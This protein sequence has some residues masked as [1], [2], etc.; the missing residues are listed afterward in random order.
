MAKKKERKAS[1]EEIAN[2]G[3]LKYFPYGEGEPL[4]CDTRNGYA[5]FVRYEGDKIRLSELDSMRE[6][7]LVDPLSVRR[8]TARW[9]REELIQGYAGRGGKDESET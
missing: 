7:E 1:T 4:W 6:A 8:L 5:R 2:D 3:S 9:T